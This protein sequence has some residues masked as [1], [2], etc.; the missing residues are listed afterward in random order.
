MNTIKFAKKLAIPL[1]VALAY[2]PAQGFAASL[3]G[4]DLA[5]FAVLGATPVV[6]CAGI[7][8]VGGNVGTSPAA[9]VTGNFVFLPA[10]GSLQLNT[11]TAQN[12]QLQL[13][14]AILAVN[15]GSAGTNVISTGDLDA[16]QAAHGG[17][18][19]PGTYDVAASTTNLDGLLKLNGLGNSNAVWRFRF[20]STLITENGSGVLVQNVGSGSGVG[21]YWTVGSAATLRGDTFAGNVFAN[22]LI[23]SDGGLTMGCGRL[24]SATGAVTLDGAVNSVSTG[25]LGIG[26]GSG[27]FDQAGV[28]SP[29]PEPET[30]AM[31]LAGL[32]LMGFVARRRQRNLAAAA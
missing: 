1:F 21:I 15:A 28:T 9:S 5:S 31:L 20:S 18:I 17:F 25:C 19:T 27:G 8:T 26:A 3:L 29:I 23:S 2:G 12:A 6:S 10:S 32:G 14:A 11:P 4:A 7:C 22:T 24:A 13:D 30:Y 16:W